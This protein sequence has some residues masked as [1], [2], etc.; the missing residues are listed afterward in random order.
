MPLP[1]ESPAETNAPVV[2]ASGNPH[3]LAEMTALFA[4]R[5]TFIPLGEAAARRGIMLAEPAETGTTFEQNAT[6][7]A[8]QY[9]SQLQMPCLAD[10]SGLE[11]DALGGRPGVI[12]SHYSSDGAELGLSRALRDAH[13]NARVISELSAVPCEQRTARFV[14][15]MC[16]AWPDDRPRSLVRGEFA[17]RIGLPNGDGEI[18]RGDNGFGYDPLFLVGPDYLRTS[19]QLSSD[20]KNARSHRASAAA[21]MLALLSKPQHT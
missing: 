3:K 1:A 17:G 13:N 14:C 18:P 7:K 19:A 4:G 5:L 12:S 6:I 21:A 9:A 20:E 16:L 8:T 2:L 11:I 15:I 10:D